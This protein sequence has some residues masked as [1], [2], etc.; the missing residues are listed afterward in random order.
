[1]VTKKLRI[2]SPDITPRLEYVA[3]IIFSSVLGIDYE[4]TDDRRKIG[5]N[6]AII[7]SDEK[8]KEQFVIRPSGLLAASGC[9]TPWSR[10]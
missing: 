3:E 4:I 1:M 2:Y 9:D 6:P 8:V 7:Y 10:R 5:G